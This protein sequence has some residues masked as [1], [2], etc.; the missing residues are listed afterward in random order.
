M[1]DHLLS[2]SVPLAPTFSPIDIKN[3]AWNSLILTNKKSE[4]PRYNLR[5]FFFAIFRIDC[6]NKSKIQFWTCCPLLIKYSRKWIYW[7]IGFSK[8]R[9]F[10]ETDWTCDAKSCHNC[11]TFVSRHFC[12]WHFKAN[13]WEVLQN[14]TTSG[15]FRW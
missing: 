6:R 14:L 11:D 12:K 2:T 3:F 15:W 1:K 4:A 10:W 8:I 9:S 7:K 13:T 5:L